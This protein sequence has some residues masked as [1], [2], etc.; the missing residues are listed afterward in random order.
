MIITVFPFIIY[1]LLMS[2]D[3]QLRSQCHIFITDNLLQPGGVSVSLPAQEKTQMSC[4]MGNVGS[5][6]FGV[7]PLPR[8]SFQLF[9]H[10]LCM[11]L[12]C[13]T[14]V[15]SDTNRLLH[16]VP[17]L[18]THAVCRLYIHIQLMLFSNKQHRLY[19]NSCLSTI[20]YPMNQR[21]LI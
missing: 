12:L 19:Y 16:N 5:N 3:S 2:A 15:L 11:H 17:L 21:C 8:I 14:M 7:W 20:N 10:L 9:C 1:K 18:A 13:V 6:R 4:T